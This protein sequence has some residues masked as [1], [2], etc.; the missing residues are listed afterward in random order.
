MESYEALRRCVAGD[1]VRVAKRL[2][3]STSLIHKWC[4]PSTDFSDSGTLNP[5]DRLEAIMEVAVAAGRPACDAL[6]P[7]YYLAQ[8]FG[9]IV[10][11]P[12]TTNASRNEYTGQLCQAVKEAGEAFATAASALED[13]EISPNERRQLG[14]EL[15]EALVALAAF[16]RMVSEG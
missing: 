5:L 7:I 16:A 14:K 4:E 9:C 8:Q 1:A 6:A 13:G 11:P 2:G 3:R 12:A 15:H 10:L